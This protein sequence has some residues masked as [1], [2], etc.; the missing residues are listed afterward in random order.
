M[1]KARGTTLAS[2]AIAG[3]LLCALV[4]LVLPPWTQADVAA[5]STVPKPRPYTGPPID[6]SNSDR[7]DFLDP[8]VCLQP[9]PNDYFTVP[10]PST[11]TGQRLN[12][13]I[14]SMPANKAGIHIDPTEYNRLDGFSPG[15]LIRFRIPGLDNPQ[16]YLYTTPRCRTKRPTP[17]TTKRNTPASP[18]SAPKT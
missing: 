1:G 3:L 9:W 13:N 5:K 18:G 12:L 6:T 10:D 7:C 16:A 17:T 15:N 8:A 2:L 4:L 11:D 14:S